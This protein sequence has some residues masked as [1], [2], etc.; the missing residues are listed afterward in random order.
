MPKAADAESSKLV[1]PEAKLW[2]HG[3]PSGKRRAQPAAA[4]DKARGQLA[5]LAAANERLAGSGDAQAAEVGKRLEFLRSRRRTWE[6][7]YE[8]ATERRQE[9]LCTLQEIEEASR[10]LE[11]L[12]RR[13]AGRAAESRES[14][15][16]GDLTH[17][18]LDLRAEVGW[19]HQRLHAA[20]AQLE[21]NM[22]RID[23]LRA[24]ASKLE[25][26][27]QGLTSRE[28]AAAAAAAPAPGRPRPARGGAG[29]SSA[30]A[31]PAAA[32][33]AAAAGAAATAAATGAA[34]DGAAAAPAAGKELR[35]WQ[36]DLAV[37]LELEEELRNHWFIV[38]FSSKLG[39]DTMVPFELFGEAWVLFRDAEGQ[40]ACVRDECAHRACPLSLGR[41]VDG[42][43]ECGLHEI[44]FEAPV[45][46]GLL[47]E[48][49]LDLAH[50]PFAHTTTFAR[51]WPVPE[52]V[53]FHAIQLL[54]GKWDPYPIDMC[55]HP[56]CVTV[57]TI[58]I[59]RPGV[60]LDSKS[61]AECR[62]HLHQMHVCLPARRGHTRLLFRMCLDFM[63]WVQH[64]PGIQSFWRYLAG[65][66]LGED[67]VLLA[68]QMDCLRRG[69]DTWRNPVPYD[70][71]G[72]RYRR[73]RNSLR[74]ARGG[75][76][77]SGDDRELGGAPTVDEEEGA[78]RGSAGHDAREAARRDRRA[79]A[80]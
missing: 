60:V 70:V 46:H 67:L 66:V 3:K 54:G 58:G 2:T 48:N 42:Q 8:E 24:D 29:P 21:R 30:A 64:V 32:A 36:R 34:G 27:Q 37:S 59:A 77:P 11:E 6:L 39:K 19:A 14:S 78:L 74:P 47:L 79:P 4:A 62:T 16:A 76:P 41:V 5:E 52:A 44:E 13:V 63:G 56:P 72:V 35:P 51:G 10:R 28:Q 71:L 80:A 7:V 50:T 1:E 38:H 9:A 73:W 25:R 22:R 23:E 18:A 45:E 40:A 57:A 26:T 43:V 68:G 33:A 20:Q 53:G 12:P 65:R 55:F 31:A 75:G 15:S 17:Q 61:A 69:G 49:L